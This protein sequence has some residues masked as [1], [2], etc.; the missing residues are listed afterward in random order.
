MTFKPEHPADKVLKYTIE[1]N[2]RRHFT[3]GNKEI[4][5]QMRLWVRQ[6]GVWVYADTLPEGL[7][8]AI[9]GCE[10]EIKRLEAT[11]AHFEELLNIKGKRNE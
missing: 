11:K 3:H 5:Q 8:S 7:R 10:H 1:T 9:K 6:D 2:P 4:D